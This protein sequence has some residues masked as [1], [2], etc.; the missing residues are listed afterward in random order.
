[1][2]EEEA[3]KERV[4]IIVLATLSSLLFIAAFVGSL[5]CWRSRRQTKKLV[6]ILSNQHRSQSLSVDYAF[7]SPP[8]A[9]HNRSFV[10]ANDDLIY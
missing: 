6:K 1:M 9:F 4:V 5:W 7:R 10:Q 2:G 8:R 3:E